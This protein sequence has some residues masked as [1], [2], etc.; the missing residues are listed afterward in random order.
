MVFATVWALELAAGMLWAAQHE[1]RWALY[2][3]AIFSAIHLFT[4]VIFMLG[5]KPQ[6]I[7]WKSV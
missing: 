2:M 3:L 4:Q 1:R 5:L 7:K 6:G